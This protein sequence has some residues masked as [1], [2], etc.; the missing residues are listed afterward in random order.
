FRPTAGER[1]LAPTLEL[2]QSLL[3]VHG[4]LLI[5]LRSG[6]GSVGTP[7]KSVKCMPVA[8]SPPLRG[9]PPG[10]AN[11]PNHLVFVVVFCAL[12]DFVKLLIELLG[13]AE[14]RRFQ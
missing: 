6:R 1:F 10:M 13:R 11:L 3:A 2:V 14:D 4:S 8:A 12:V 9:H 5:L 7:S